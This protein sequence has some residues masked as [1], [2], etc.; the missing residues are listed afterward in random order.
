MIYFATEYT[1]MQN[2]LGL[3]K[4]FIKRF[5]SIL[6]FSKKKDLLMQGF[7]QSTT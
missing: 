1:I 2:L 4:I 7:E 5:T 3:G 6:I